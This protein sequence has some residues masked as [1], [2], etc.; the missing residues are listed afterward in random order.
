[1][2]ATRGM[3]ITLIGLLLALGGFVF[4]LR[5]YPEGYAVLIAAWSV[6]AMGWVLDRLERRRE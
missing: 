4:G 2:R 1:M 5:W 3:E 6:S